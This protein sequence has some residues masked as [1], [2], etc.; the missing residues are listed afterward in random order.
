MRAG[1]VGVLLGRN[2]L[3]NVQQCHRSDLSGSRQNCFVALAGR[4][5]LLLAFSSFAHCCAAVTRLRL[6]IDTSTLI[7]HVFWTRERARLAQTGTVRRHSR[8][9]PHTTHP[10]TDTHSYARTYIHRRALA[11]GQSRRGHQHTLIAPLGARAGHHSS[12]VSLCLFRVICWLL[13]RSCVCL[14]VRLGRLRRR[15]RT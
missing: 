6:A 4:V 2:A 5:A 8:T 7:H 9:Q 3:H 12:S 10:R 14:R 1:A 15:W 13:T 11:R